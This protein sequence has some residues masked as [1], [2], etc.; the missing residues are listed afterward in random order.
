MPTAGKR[1]ESS[2][3]RKSAYL[4]LA[5]EKARTHLN[6]P[7]GNKWLWVRIPCG[8]FRENSA[9][10]RRR[11]R[12]MQIKVIVRPKVP[13]DA[14]NWV[15]Y[16][17]FVVYAKS[18]HVRAETFTV[19]RLQVFLASDS[20]L[21]SCLCLCVCFGHAT[22]YHCCVSKSQWRSKLLPNNRTGSANIYAALRLAWH[23]WASSRKLNAKCEKE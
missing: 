9:R 4:Q 21:L 11:R 14:Y 8:L 10:W 7:T 6:F 16:F 23:G 18:Q 19:L 22:C 2:S 12:R 15:S 5:S 13:T 3:Q 20:F 1:S 17:Q